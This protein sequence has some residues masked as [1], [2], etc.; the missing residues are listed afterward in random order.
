MEWSK[1]DQKSRILAGT[2]SSR[3]LARMIPY[4]DKNRSPPLSLGFYEAFAH[5]VNELVEDAVDRTRA[6][7]RRTVPA[8]DV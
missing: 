3:R 4:P 5:R 8:K 6:N 7:Q 2:A 1:V